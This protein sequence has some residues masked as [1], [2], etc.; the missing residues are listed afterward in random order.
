MKFLTS[1]ELDHQEYV[2]CIDQCKSNPNAAAFKTVIRKGTL[3]EL[4][5]WCNAYNLFN[6]QH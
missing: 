1:Y 2:K 6:L 3:F 5:F 4:D